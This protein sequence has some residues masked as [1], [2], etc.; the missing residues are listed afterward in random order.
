MISLSELKIGE[1]AEILEIS[2]YELQVP[3]M[4]VGVIPGETFV[5]SEIAPFGDPVALDFGGTKIAIRKSH[6]SAIKV[7]RVG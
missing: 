5:V 2:D 1:R 7:R 3:L 4:S 6:L